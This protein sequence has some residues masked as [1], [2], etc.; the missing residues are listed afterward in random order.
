MPLQ[1]IAISPFG[2]IITGSSLRSGGS[3]AVEVD[4]DE[5]RQ[6]VE[7][8]VRHSDGRK[9]TLSVG[10]TLSSTVRSSAEWLI[11][12]ATSTERIPRRDRTPQ[13]ESGIDIYDPGVDDYSPDSDGADSF[14]AARDFTLQVGSLGESDLLQLAKRIFSRHVMFHSLREE[15][16][17]V[18]QEAARC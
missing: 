15:A 11:T 4:P 13:S 7:T 6:D 9:R 12:G 18:A 14:V 8:P 17:Y 1:S 5:L 10:S 3:L 16:A 2:D